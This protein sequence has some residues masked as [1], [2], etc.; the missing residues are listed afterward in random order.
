MHVRFGSKA[1]VKTLH[2]DVDFEL[3][4]KLGAGKLPNDACC[5]GMWTAIRP[6]PTH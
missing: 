2:F 1:E 6:P 4:T 3:R 5:S